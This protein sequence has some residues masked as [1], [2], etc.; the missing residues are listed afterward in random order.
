MRCTNLA[1]LLIAG[2]ILNFI[3]PAAGKDIPGVIHPPVPAWAAGTHGPDHSILNL[4]SIHLWIRSDG[5]SPYSFSPDGV[6][7]TYPP[8]IPA[9]FSEG[10][11]WGAKVSNGTGWQRVRVN[12][13]TYVTGLKAGK[14]LY[15]GG[16]NVI[17]SEDPAIRH[18][19]R[20][21][22][23]Y[24]TADLT[25]DAASFFG[26]EP[27]A[28][29]SS[30]IEA[31]FAQYDYDWINWPAGEGAPF[32]DAGSDG[33][34]DPDVDIPGEPGAA[35][36][37]WLVAN[38]LPIIE[39]TDTTN[40][41]HLSYGSPPIGLEM[42]LTLW[43]YAPAAS[44]LSAN[45][46]FKRI[47]LVYTGLAGT[48][49][50]ATLDTLYISQ[51]SDPDLGTYTDDFVGWHPELQLA[52]VYNSTPQ[53]R[54]ATAAGYPP[55]AT[56]Y[57]LVDSPLN[58]SG[59]SD[60]SSFVYFGPG[61]GLSDPTYGIYSGSLQFFNLMEGFLPRPEYP[62]QEPWIDPTTGQATKFTLSGNPV[63]GTGWVDGIQLPPGDRRMIASY[64]PFSLALGDSLEL[65]IGIVGGIGVANLESVVQL[66]RQAMT[67][68]KNY[69]AGWP[70][71]SLEAEPDFTPVNTTD[72]F[73]AA[74]TGR[75]LSSL[76]A[77]LED[78]AGIQVTS[79]A[80]FDDGTHGDGT[81]GD[82]LYAGS[83]TVSPFQRPLVLSLELTEGGSSDTLTDIGRVTTDGPLIVDTLVVTSD[84]R[85]FDGLINPG[86]NIHLSLAVTN[87]GQF[88]HSGL[89]A[90]TYY[91]GPLTSQEE[92]VQWLPDAASGASVTT[93][94]DVTDPGTYSVAQISDSIGD[95]D[96]LTAYVLLMDDARNIWHDLVTLPIEPFTAEP[97]APV[98]M[99]HTAGTGGGRFGYHIIAPD[100]LNGGH[101]YELTISD[102]IDEDHTPG[103]SL[104]DLTDDEV[105]L[106]N[107]PL[108]DPYSHNVPLTEGFRTTQGTARYEQMLDWSSDG[109]RWISAT[110]WGAGTFFGGADLACNFFGSSLDPD[111][112]FSIR[113]VFQDQVKVYVFGNASKGAVYRRDLG[114]AYAG[115][116]ELPFS[117][118]ELGPDSSHVRR[119]NI[120]FV[121]YENPEDGYPPANL[122]WDMGWYG[123]ATG[124]SEGEFAPA[125]GREYLFVHATT[126]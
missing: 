84:H 12:G 81:A 108:P 86:E 2:L 43:T 80:L 85:N 23:D 21:R 95:G 11:V 113:L 65:T 6:A 111:S 63:A 35:Q 103:F 105:L 5:Y 97:F 104:S 90:A 33:L 48:S 31:V 27:G 39:G 61:S 40:I 8:G 24:Q 17:G 116:G 58:T 100:E 115:A 99:E 71:L 47:R 1:V 20:V 46:L 70:L 54:L 45:S 10:I 82:F 91:E 106:H 53:D 83:L 94:Y 13:S 112:V 73:V 4:S 3:S 75:T 87:A 62:T 74:R 88:A 52:Y 89:G 92:S 68:R 110:N 76:V 29:T 102:S 37:I 41:S 67:T 93:P 32:Y 78:E 57:M 14:V 18:T 117:A 30:D 50:N 25:E 119:L 49:P 64:G 124:K 72:I 118:W 26:I 15:D 79:G 7:G 60:A 114:Y 55:P 107:C 56:G 77:I 122:L 126:Y 59:T 109:D 101:L 120:S 98:L 121:E 19:W 9:I 34:Y 51:W 123:T 66:W 16:G 96:V 28:V 44:V 125:G 22:R 42:Q 69:A 36:T 38:D